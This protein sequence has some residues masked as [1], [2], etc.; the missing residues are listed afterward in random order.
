MI[1]SLIV[2]SKLAFSEHAIYLRRI[3]ANPPILQDEHI[4]YKLLDVAG[5][6]IH[7]FQSKQYEEAAMQFDRVVKAN[8]TSFRD[9]WCYLL[10]MTNLFQVKVDEAIAMLLTLYRKPVFEFN[11]ECLS[12]CFILN[13]RA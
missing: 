8:L 4:S 12:V 10:A 3:V 6:G 9:N 13:I 2:S 1:S 7:Y 5:L 11:R